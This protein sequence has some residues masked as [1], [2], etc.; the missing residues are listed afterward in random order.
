MLC[1]SLNWG[2][3]DSIETCFWNLNIL[4]FCLNYYIIILFLLHMITRFLTRQL[5][6]VPAALTVTR[7]I[8]LRRDGTNAILCF[9]RARNGT[10]ENK[11]VVKCVS[12]TYKTQLN[13]FLV[14]F[15]CIYAILAYRLRKKKPTALYV[16]KC[17]RLP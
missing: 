11:V 16:Q 6:I 7:W 3:Q 4:S 15:N 17:S 2:W 13:Q 5:P 9:H 14:T 12:H 10:Q 8:P 1:T